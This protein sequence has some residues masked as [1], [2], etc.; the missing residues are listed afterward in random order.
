MDN[1]GSDFGISELEGIL[2]LEFISEILGL[3]LVDYLGGTSSG[4]SAIFICFLGLFT[5]CFFICEFFI[6]CVTM[7]YGI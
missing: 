3:F 6:Y 5:P 4:F 7:G 2:L 1:F